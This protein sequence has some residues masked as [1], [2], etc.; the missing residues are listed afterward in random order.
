MVDD[1]RRLRELDAEVRNTIIKIQFSSLPDPEK[2]LYMFH[3]MPSNY[4]CSVLADVEKD[5]KKKMSVIVSEPKQPPELD[6]TSE[7]SHVTADGA[8]QALVP[9]DLKLEVQ[10]GD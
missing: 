3:G 5:E 6:Y 4:R 9:H 1:G 7:P 8:Q 10:V 2:Y